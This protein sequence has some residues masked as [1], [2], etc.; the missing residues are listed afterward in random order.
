MPTLS[1]VISPGKGERLE[2]LNEFL[3]VSLQ[4]GAEGIINHQ[5]LLLASF[6]IDAD[7]PGNCAAHE[8]LVLDGPMAGPLTD[9]GKS[10]QPAQRKQPR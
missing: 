1:P 4:A 6:G 10:P 3:V 7:T 2:W 8:Q 9:E 5:P